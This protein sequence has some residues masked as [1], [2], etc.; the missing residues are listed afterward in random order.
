MNSPE[1]HLHG[2]PSEEGGVPCAFTELFEEVYPPLV[3]VLTAKCRSRVV[4]ED[5]AQEVFE[6]G[7]AHWSTLSTTDHPDRWLFRVGLNLASSYFRRL[8]AERRAVGRLGERPIQLVESGESLD[9]WRAIRGLT[10]REQEV[11]ALRFYGSLSVRETAEVLQIADG[12]VKAL[13]HRAT[14]KLE[15]A[16][17]RGDG[18]ADE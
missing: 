18:E 6:R 17:Q 14:R 8:N 4:A 1:N 15:Q 10:R 2:E 3:R 5:L 13:T 7:L 9:L 11:V 12:T 16:L